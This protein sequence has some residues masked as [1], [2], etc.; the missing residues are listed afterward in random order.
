MSGWASEEVLRAYRGQGWTVV[1]GAYADQGAQLAG[2]VDELE[3]LPP[4]I[5][6]PLM[7]HASGELDPAPRPIRVECFLEA[8]PDIARWLLTDELAATLTAVLG[9]PPTLFKDKVIFKV[10]GAQGFRPHQD[11]GYGWHRFARRYTIAAVAIDDAGPENGWLEVVSGS[12]QQ[13]LLAPRWHLLDEATAD[14]L[15]FEPVPMRRGDLLLLD[16]FTVHR[17]AP[18][19][20]ASRRAMVY[21]TFNARSDGDHRARY[22]ETIPDV[23]RWLVLRTVLG[24]ADEESHA[25]EETHAG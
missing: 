13:G 11:Y 12:H 10:P 25:D 5:E 3:R 22:F 9:E 16:A 20:S 23:R 19:L 15:R 6:P 14:T 2:A 17:S 18:N 24:S 1:R 4:S 7:Y 21:L 8:R